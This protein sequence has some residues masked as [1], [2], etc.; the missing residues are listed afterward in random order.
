MKLYE[1]LIQE[2]DVAP[3]MVEI[4][5]TIIDIDSNRLEQLGIDLK[6]ETSNVSVLGSAAGRGGQL[7]FVNPP[8]VIGSGLVAGTVLGSAGNSL[9]A[10]IMALSEKGDARIVSRPKVVTM[11]NVEALISN[12]K[13]FN[14]KV[15]GERQADLFT[16]NY[17]LDMRVTPTVVGDKETRE[18]RLVVNI[19]DGS[20][21]AASV[22]AIPVINRSS[23]STQSLVRQGDSLLIGG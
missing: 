14:I 9:V 3:Q 22:D 16:V 15:A 1:D 8:S 19:Q 4:E 6:L 5:A 20:S 10:R 12:T 23:L 7:N 21:Q 2:L 17:G 18:F 11:N 13:E